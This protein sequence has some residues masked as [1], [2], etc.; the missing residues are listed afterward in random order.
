MTRHLVIAFLCTSTLL[1][2][3]SA[4]DSATVSEPRVELRLMEPKPIEDLTEYRG[5]KHGY[6]DNDYGY[7]HKKPARVLNKQSVAKLEIWRSYLSPSLKKPNGFT[8]KFH[9]TEE[10]RKQIADHAGGGDWQRY[11]VV[12]V[13]GKQVGGLQRYEINNCKSAPPDCRAESF[14]SDSLQ[15]K[16]RTRLLEIA[17]TLTD[18]VVID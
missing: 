3:A 1:G 6:G 12:V 9:L 4:Q 17:K 7:L 2:H 5:I 18:T 16:S 8:M 13:D 14:N 15:L 10:A 11:V